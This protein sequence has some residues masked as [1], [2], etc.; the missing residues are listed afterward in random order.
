MSISGLVTLLAQDGI[1]GLQA[2]TTGGAWVDVPPA[3]GG[4]AV[5]FGGLLQRWTGGR[6]R[7]TEHRVVGDFAERRSIPFFYEPAAD[8]RI[9]PL[10]LSGFPDFEPF[11]YGD[12]LWSSMMRFVEFRGLEHA[13]RPTGVR[14][15]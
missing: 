6:I 4:L 1:A 9:A 3:E 8:A 13:R 11:A 14:A 7:A 12:H 5:N 15:A 10:P 2:R